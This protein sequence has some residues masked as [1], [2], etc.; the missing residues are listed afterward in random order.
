MSSIAERNHEA[1]TLQDRLDDLA[2]D[3]D[4]FAVNY[5]H[6]IESLFARR[7]QIVVNEVLHLSRLEGMKVDRVLDRKLDYFI[8]FQIDILRMVILFPVIS[9]LRIE[10]TRT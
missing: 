5:A 8:F 2:Q 10:R 7:F 6:L 9:L 3:A 4:A 1:V